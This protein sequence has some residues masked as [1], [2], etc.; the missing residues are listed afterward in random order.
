[1]IPRTLFGTEHEDFRS[2]VRRFYAEEI[3]PFHAKWEQQ[4]CVDRA[5]WLRAGELG[6][7]CMTIPEI[8]GGAGAD[9]RYSAVMMEEQQRA[10]ASGV[11]FILHSDIVAN[12]LNNFGSEQQ[13]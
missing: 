6:M 13:K 12:Y 11:G 5:I 7:L 8:Y 1:M 2:S 3:M 9:R 4:Q 10:G